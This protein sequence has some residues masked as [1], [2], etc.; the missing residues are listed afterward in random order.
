MRI[1]TMQDAISLLPTNKSAIVVAGSSREIDL[2]KESLAEALPHF[3]HIHQNETS[4]MKEFRLDATQRAVLYGMDKMGTGVD[5]PGRIGL[6]II[7][8]PINGVFPTYATKHAHCVGL[9]RQKSL[10]EK[11]Y[12][13]IRMY[14]TTQAAGRLQRLKSDGGVILFLSDK[15]NEASRL[16][17]RY[18]TTRYERQPIVTD[19]RY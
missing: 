17:K 3:H 10:V 9:A 2:I 16:A 11:R 8:R 13:F 1:Q 19:F 5:L 6:V 15:S 7:P 12:N 14:R 4:R 18:G